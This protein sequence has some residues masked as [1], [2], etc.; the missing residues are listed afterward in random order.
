MRSVINDP[1][2]KDSKITQTTIYCLV[3][4][5]SLCTKM[6]GNRKTT[7][8]AHFHQI[9]DLSGLQGSRESSASKSSASEKRKNTDS[10]DKISF[11]KENSILTGIFQIYTS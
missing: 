2:S 5:V 9:Q 8:F 3:C 6:I 10:E 1:K 11:K 4:L 7:C